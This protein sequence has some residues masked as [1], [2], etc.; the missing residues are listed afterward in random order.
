MAAENYRGGTTHPSLY[1]AKAIHKML[2]EKF[3]QIPD[4]E[5][6]TFT[7]GGC[8][9]TNLQGLT[10]A[11][12]VDADFQ[13]LLSFE[14]YMHAHLQ[15]AGSFEGFYEGFCVALEKEI[16]AFLDR[17]VEQYEYR[18]KYLPNPMR[19]LFFDDC[20][21]KE[22]DF[23]AGGARYTWIQSAH[24]GLINVIDS[25]IAVRELIF[26]KKRF[27]AEEFIQKLTDEDPDFY[28]ILA[29]CPCYGTGNEDA[30][31]LA[32]D[33]AGRVYMVYHNKPPKSFIEAYLLTE[34]QFQR[35]EY[36][37]T[38]VGA[39][40]DGRRK[41]EA[42]GDSIAAIRGKAK[43]G[44]TAMLRSA[45]KLP[46][47]LAEG[48]SVLNLTIN[49]NFTDEMLKGLIKGYFALGGI[50]V[51]VTCTSVEELRDA[52]EHP[53]KHRDLIVR[54]GGYSDYFINL[55]PG[56]RKAVVERNVHELGA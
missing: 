3:P 6:A 18:A 4:E 25:L 27:T 2:K 46:Q 19:T 5:L 37:G 44:P 41:G 47:N 11:G 43:E 55:T 34:H 53:E 26:R 32:A 33:F 50:Q 14:N 10:R 45:A 7:G 39:T 17:I 35:Y 13:L 31:S 16:D 48:I 52:L 22:K 38:L 40:P 42:L 15:T 56:L 8:T 54:V 9:E 36:D 51:Q 21:A 29:S 1:N 23:N 20:I 28:Q 12:G 24:S 30:D 49:R